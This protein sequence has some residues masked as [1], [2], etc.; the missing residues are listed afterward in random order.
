M[1]NRPADPV[2]C[3]PSTSEGTRSPAVDERVFRAL[4]EATHEALLTIDPNGRIIFWNR[5]AE[6]IFGWSANEA[7]G[8]D[9][10]DL[11]V[12]LRF[13]A[14]H[15]ASFEVFR[16]TGTGGAVGKTFELAA[17]RKDGSES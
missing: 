1:A 14:A 17:L 6:T 7:L 16:T 8:R 9:L 13:H 15:R 4:A 10:H 12:P 11:I 2:D 3:S 5:A